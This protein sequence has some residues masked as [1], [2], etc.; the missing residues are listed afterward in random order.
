MKLEEM[1]QLR[2][3]EAISS[4]T[5]DFFQ[6]IEGLCRFLACMPRPLSFEITNDYV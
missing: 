5:T 1:G 4:W 6:Y 2:P 3:G